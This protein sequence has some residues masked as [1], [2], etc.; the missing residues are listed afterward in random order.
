MDD[1]KFPTWIIHQR[2]G[3]VPDKKGPFHETK[4]I[5]EFLRD[6]YSLYPGSICI[7][8]ND[9]GAAGWHPQHGFEWLDEFGDKRRRHPRK[10]A[11]DGQTMPIGYLRGSDREMLKTGSVCLYKRRDW[12]AHIPV[13]AYPSPETN[14]TFTREQM[15]AEVE[16]RVDRALAAQQALSSP[17]V[18]MDAKVSLQQQLAEMRA[19]RDLLQDILDSRPAI[20]A[21][22]PESY[23][24]WSQAIYSGDVVRAAGGGSDAP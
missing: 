20:N 5:E 9:L 16:R 21:A 8:V 23:N 10:D 1:S 3:M 12:Q 7:V 17:K 6:L 18:N 19:E 24:R 2:Y 14:E 4:R 13:Y 22:L 11:H 15:L